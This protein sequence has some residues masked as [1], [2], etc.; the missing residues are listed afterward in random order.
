VKTTSWTGKERRK[1]PRYSINTGVELKILDDSEKHL[2]GYHGY[3]KNI[4][5][6]GICVKLPR[7]KAVAYPEIKEKIKLQV[8]IPVLDIKEYLELNGKI[9][10]CLQKGK[11]C[12]ISMQFILN[13]K[14]IEETLSEFVESIKGLK[15]QRKM[16][17]KYLTRQE[18]QQMLKLD[19]VE[20]LALVKSKKIRAY[21]L[22]NEI[23]FK[24]KDLEKL[25]TMIEP[26]K[27]ADTSKYKE[28]SL[29]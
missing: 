5:L 12:N 14:E 9:V 15:E 3:T 18:V 11:D 25:M 26:E 28:E 29:F 6:G 27:K 23:V 16:I 17:E 1:H 24:Y 10:R 7:Y 20:M 4:S 8:R 22:D 2:I 13:D 21:R 19:I